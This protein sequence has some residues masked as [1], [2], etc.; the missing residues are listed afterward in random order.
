MRYIYVILTV[1]ILSSACNAQSSPNAP[2]AATLPAS[3]NTPPVTQPA[4]APTTTTTQPINMSSDEVIRVER[5][6]YKQVVEAHQKT[7]ATIEWA[8]GIIGSLLIILM[9]YVVFKNNKE[10]KDALEQAKEAKNDAKEAC[11]EA[12]HWESESKRILENIDKQ[13]KE[14]LEKIK[15][16]GKESIEDIVKQT[17]TQMRINELWNSALR[18]EYD[19]KYEEACDKYA[20]IVTL[21]PEDYWAYNN[22]GSTLCYWARLKSDE[23]IF[24]QACQKFEQA[25]RIYPDRHEAY[26]NWGAALGERAEIKGDEKLFEQACKI[27]EKSFKIK[28][29]EYT[30]YTNWGSTLC[31]WARLKGDEKLFEQARQKFEQAVNIKPNR[32]EAFN[33]LA[34]TL[35]YRA[36]LAVGKPEYE[37]LLNQAEEKSL[38]AES[39]ETGAGAYNLACIYAKRSDKDRCKIWLLVGQEAETLMTREQAMKDGDLDTVRDEPWFKEIKWKGEK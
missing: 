33:G 16:Q 4:L 27:F 38:K 1:L 30:L 9:G 35:L 32:S 7:L 11:K 23:K 6:V 13:V 31:K 37:D 17:Q 18:L 2:P 20:E 5:D 39:L 19:G 24:E 29:N 10:Y 25:T 36:Q 28:S 22:W 12:R 34:A 26:L 15:K 8:I 3:P 21:R 14:E